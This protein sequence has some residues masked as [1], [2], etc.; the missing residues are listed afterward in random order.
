MVV[1]NISRVQ[2]ELVNVNS[3]ITARLETES[4]ARLNIFVQV[5]QQDNW[6]SETPTPS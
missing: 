4:L 6:G 3:V 5:S 2:H 1:V